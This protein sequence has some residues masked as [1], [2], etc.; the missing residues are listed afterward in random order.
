[1]SNL[2]FVLKM[3]EGSGVATLGKTV[4]FANDDNVVDNGAS[5]AE[6]PGTRISNKTYLT[7]IKH[8]L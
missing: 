7:H 8:R 3:I 1:M 2:Q 5:R 4:K 6:S